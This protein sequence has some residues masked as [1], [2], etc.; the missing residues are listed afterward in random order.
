MTTDSNSASV[1]PVA[2]PTTDLTDF[3]SAAEARTDRW[4][5]MQA[6]VRAWQSA[7]G[8]T[9]PQDTKRYAEAVALFGDLAMLEAFFA[10]PGPRVMDAIEQAL[11]ERNAGV[12]GKLVQAVSSALMTDTY[13]TDPGA[14]DPLRE[15]GSRTHELLPPDLQGSQTQK[16]YFEI[17]IVTGADPS[18]WEQARADI[19]RLRRPDDPFLYEIVQV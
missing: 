12:C 6:T 10:Y 5:Q 13:R 4:R 19:K 9:D 15:E 16:P 17:L 3:F 18:G 1:T 8:G 14:W 11:A 7:A 2:P